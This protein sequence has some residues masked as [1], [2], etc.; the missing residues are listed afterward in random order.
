MLPSAPISKPAFQRAVPDFGCAGLPPRAADL[1]VWLP[2]PGQPD[3]LGDELGGTPRPL[4]G[5]FGGYGAGKL[6]GGPAGPLPFQGAH[7]VSE[8]F[9]PEGAGRVIEQAELRARWT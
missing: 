3:R 4:D 9:E 6:T 7:G 8:F 2:R 5:E 1:G